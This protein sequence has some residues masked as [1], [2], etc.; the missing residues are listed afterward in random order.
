MVP[1]GDVIH[2]RRKT[3]KMTLEAVGKAAGG[4]SKGYMSGIENGKVNPPSAKVTARLAEALK[5][6][7]APFQMLAWLQKAPAAVKKNTA[8][9]Q[10]CS[11]VDR[12]PM[13]SQFTP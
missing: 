1:F 9:M 7:P 6:Y 12:T 2:S 11:E 3:L 13:A 4:L 10:L 5:L 8:Y